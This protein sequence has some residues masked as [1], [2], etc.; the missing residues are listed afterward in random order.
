MKPKPFHL[1]ALCRAVRPVLCGLVAA[2]GAGLVHGEKTPSKPPGKAAPQAPAGVPEPPLPVVNAGAAPLPDLAPLPP[3]PQLPDA[4]TGANA[5]SPI[6]MQGGAEG[7]AQT[8]G[9]PPGQTLST[10]INPKITAS[11]SASGQFRVY[12]RD[13]QTRSPFTSRCDEMADRL[14]RLLRDDQP[15]VL[16]VVIAVKTA[17]DIR[18]NGPAVATGISQI[19]DGGFHLQL[20]VQVRPDL[21]PADF[22][23]ELARILIAER[24]LRNQREISTRRSMVLPDWLLT[25]ISQAMTFRERSKPSAVFTAIFRSGKIYGIDEILDTSPGRLDALSRTIYETSCCAL[26]LALLDQPD[27]PMRLRKFLSMLAVD[28]R[29]D[30]ELLNVCFPSLALSA[31]SL[32][33]WWSLQMAALATPTV[34]EAL[35]ATDTRTALREALMIR[36]DTSPEAMPKITSVP[37]D[38]S[39]GA[40]EKKRGLIGRLLGLGGAGAATTKPAEEPA[41][42]PVPAPDKPQAQPEA[43]K[44]QSGP[45]PKPEVPEDAAEARKYG[46]FGRLF[47][48]SGTT[49]EA[50]GEDKPAKKEDK[51]APKPVAKPA[52]AETPPKKPNGT[53]PAADEPPPE[54][55]KRGFFGRIFGGSD[56][57]NKEEPA[58]ESKP[59]KKSGSKSKGGD[60]SSDGEEKKKS[61]ATNPQA[62]LD[63]AL[64]RFAAQAGSWAAEARSAWAAYVAADHHEVKLRLPFGRKKTEEKKAEE[65]APEEKPKDE[66]P[67]VGEKTKSAAQPAAGASI[68]P[69]APAATKLVPSLPK[70]VP[71]S[72]PIEEYA[73]IMKRKDRAAILDRTI[74]QLRTLVPHAHVLF[75]PVINEYIELVTDLRNG[76]TRDGDKRLATL[77]ERTESTYA[78]A[79]AVQDYLDFYETN[80]TRTY[81]SAFDDYLKVR[82]QIQ[83]ELPVRDDPISRLLDSLDAESVR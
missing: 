81:S 57:S 21:R 25:G 64:A 50:D 30:R 33:K 6:P 66:K 70:L 60:D 61:A 15:W 78:Q 5:L 44:P 46:L 28:S 68:T 11:T 24:I 54:P 10:G 35:G 49:A 43:T 29:E 17:P 2:L 53:K 69:P 19:A 55:K 62:E 27:G 42:A 58:P 37:A 32:N 59:E 56:S 38:G 16:P 71:V 73:N 75:R 1:T 20:T 9:A 65:P 14:R 47:G 23:A 40:D 76:R 13:L 39:A 12:G 74:Q 4:Q 31:S 67:A 26:V 77:R 51:P 83:R 34:F 72:I 82:D 48:A 45:P 63:A 7:A 8:T 79:K 18:L 80:Q 22:D 52:P 3:L 36:Y 41:A